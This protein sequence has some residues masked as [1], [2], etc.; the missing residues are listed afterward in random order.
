MLSWKSELTLIHLLTIAFANSWKQDGLYI[1]HV[2]S[3][4]HT[5]SR[6]VGALCAG[7]WRRAPPRGFIYPGGSI[8]P[9]ERKS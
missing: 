3:I 8:Q 4:G 1:Y 2:W 6:R 5:W 7:G 9:S